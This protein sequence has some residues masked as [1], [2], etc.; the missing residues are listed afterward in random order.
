MTRIPDIGSSLLPVHC[1]R[2]GMRRAGQ[3]G[4]SLAVAVLSTGDSRRELARGSTPGG[5]RV[6]GLRTVCEAGDRNDLSSLWRR[7]ARRACPGVGGTS[8]RCAAARSGSSRFGAPPTCGYLQSARA[9]PAAVEQ[10]QREHDVA[11]IVPT[12]RGL[13]ERQQ[14]LFLLL[15]GVIRAQ[16]T[17]RSA[18]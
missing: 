5:R 1:G 2:P 17:T 3:S 18:P 7:K 16:A 13:T 6:D 12:I 9:H 4:V 15:L 8:A 10:R 11:I 14:Q